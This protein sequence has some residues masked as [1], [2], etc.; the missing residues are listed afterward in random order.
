M[1]WSQCQLWCASTY[2]TVCH[3]LSTHLLSLHPSSSSPSFPP[4]TPST[5]SPSSFSTYSQEIFHQLTEQARVFSQKDY[6]NA[7]RLLAH[8]QPS[9]SEEK[10]DMRLKQLETIFSKDAVQK[11]CTDT[12]YLN[13]LQSL[14]YISKISCFAPGNIQLNMI[15][16]ISAN[17]KQE[18]DW[19]A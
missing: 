18:A 11:H 6:A 8:S 3:S 12:K 1:G 14:W 7:L 4:C 15:L 16:Y 2:G 17:C 5:P 19:S 13:G 9:F 10:L